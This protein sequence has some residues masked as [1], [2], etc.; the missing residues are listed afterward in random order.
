[1]LMSCVQLG[2]SVFKRKSVQYHVKYVGIIFIY[3]LFKYFTR[4]QLQYCQ[5]DLEK[6][7]EYPLKKLYNV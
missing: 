2:P 4:N 1:M 6:K 3:D 7:A 5:I